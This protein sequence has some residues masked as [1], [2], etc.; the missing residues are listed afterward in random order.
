MNIEQQL[1]ELVIS[2]YGSVRNF[3]AMIGM[4]NSTTDSIFKR[5]ILNSSVTSIIKICDVLQ[6]S[7]DSL[8]RGHIEPRTGQSP[9]IQLTG[10]EVELLRIYRT[11]NTT[12]KDLLMS[13]AK[14]YDGNPEMKQDKS[15]V[16]A[17]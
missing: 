6:I 16:K 13:T 15:N 14:A 4:P 1:K 11:L 5:G 17:I 2:K 10:N 9:A 12:G 8:S 3:S 7:V